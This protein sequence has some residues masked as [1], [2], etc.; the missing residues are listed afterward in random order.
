MWGWQSITVALDGFTW[1]PASNTYS[2]IAE[3]VMSPFLRAG[4]CSCRHMPS[5][6]PVWPMY[7]LGYSAHWMLQASPF[8][9]DTGTESLEWN[10]SCFRVLR[11]RF[12]QRVRFY[13]RTLY[14]SAWLT[15]TY[16]SPFTLPPCIFHLLIYPISACLFPLF[17]LCS[18]MPH[19]TNLFVHPALVSLSLM[20]AAVVLLKHLINLSLTW[21]VFSAYILIVTILSL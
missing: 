14:S 13:T 7:V 21:L 19:V 3:A 10:N 2:A 17:F 16:F 8:F 9:L 11:G 18:F 20:K 5:D 1:W 12:K 15:Y 4:S 6:L